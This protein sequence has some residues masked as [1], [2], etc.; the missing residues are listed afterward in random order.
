MHKSLVAVID[1]TKARIL[2]LEV[3]EFSADGIDPRL[4]EHDAVL[5]TQDT[6]GQDLWSSTKTGRNRG[7][8]GQAH[9]YDD[10]RE[11]H[12]VEFER[13]FAHTIAAQLA[14]LIQVHQLQHLLLVA[15]P[16]TLGLVREACTAALP[17]HLQIT[18][19][20]KDL[21]HFTP[22][23]LHQYLAGQGLLP[24]PVRQSRSS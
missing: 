21:C 3:D 6:Q 13:R 14:N 1:S 9:S 16:Q 22:H 20:A 2:T 17:S 12:V 8:S 10:H 15:A 24:E 7:V 5:N 4:I 18:E 11:D 19:L 23:K